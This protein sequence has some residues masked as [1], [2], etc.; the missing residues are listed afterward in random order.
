MGMWIQPANSPQK[1]RQQYEITYPI[2]SYDQDTAHCRSGGGGLLPPR[3]RQQQRRQCVLQQNSYPPHKLSRSDERTLK[4]GCHRHRQMCA[5]LKQTKPTGSAQ[6]RIEFTIGSTAAQMVRQRLFTAGDRKA[7]RCERIE[8][9]P[10]I[11]GSPVSLQYFLRG[12]R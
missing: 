10:T 9:V 8:C 5:G 7:R 6:L 11:C 4:Y 1:W 12:S 2:Q 3:P